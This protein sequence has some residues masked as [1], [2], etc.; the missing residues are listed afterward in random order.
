[1]RL[2]GSRTWLFIGTI[3]IAA[4]DAVCWPTPKGAPAPHSCWTC[5]YYTHELMIENIS[6]YR[7]L[8][9]KEVERRAEEGFQRVFRRKLLDPTAT[10]RG[11]IA[12][13]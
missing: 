9:Y 13:T 6:L 1:M 8:G 11:C 5:V 10:S 2:C 3:T 7:R 12:S 4:L